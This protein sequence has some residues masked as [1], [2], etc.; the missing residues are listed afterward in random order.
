MFPRIN[1][2]L[3]TES[4]MPRRNGHFLP[5]SHHFYLS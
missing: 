5:K 1:V 2:R 4:P 3:E